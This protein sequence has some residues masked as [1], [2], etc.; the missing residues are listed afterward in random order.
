M[1]H[2]NLCLYFNDVNVGGN[3]YVGYISASDGVYHPQ[4]SDEKYKT[5]VA[6][7]DDV[8]HKMDQIRGVF[9]DW[10]DLYK[11]SHYGA[12]TK[13]QIGMI[14]QEV[15]AVFP[16]L[17]EEVTMRDMKFLGLDYQKFTAV[18]VQAVKE[19]KAMNESL[20]DRVK[21]LEAPTKTKAKKVT[22]NERPA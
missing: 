21:A 2:H 22:D 1:S 5:N 17:V 9:F 13:R 14:A 19:L 11:A 8:L 7:L 18:L 20:S 16:E 6:T 3:Y 12:S 4:S 10:N 15:Q